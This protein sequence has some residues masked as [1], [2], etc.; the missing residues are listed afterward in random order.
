MQFTNVY[1]VSLCHGG[2]CGTK[3]DGW[4]ADL[5]HHLAEPAVPAADEILHGADAGGGVVD[6]DAA[7]G[8]GREPHNP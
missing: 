3:P 2:V 4:G 5:Q 6:L 1:Q 8:G 7:L